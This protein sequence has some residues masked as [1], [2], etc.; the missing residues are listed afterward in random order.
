MPTLRR[1]LRALAA[2]LVAL[3]ALAGGGTPE[4]REVPPERATVELKDKAGKHLELALEE[5]AF[6]RLLL[7]LKQTGKPIE[8]RVEIAGLFA[9]FHEVRAVPDLVA[10]VQAKNEPMALKTAALW[11]LGEIGHPRGMPAFQ[12]VLMQLYDLKDNE[13]KQAKGITVEG[14]G[15]KERTISLREMC[16][17]RLGRLAE[18]VLLK[19]GADEN[20]GLVDIL[21]EPLAKGITPEKPPDE[22]DPANGRRRAALISVAAVG[23]RSPTAIR[24]LTDVLTADDNCYPWDFKLIATEA[25]ST[26][27]IRRTEEFRA[28]GLKARDR[29]SDDIAAALIQAFG[30]TDFPEVREIGG[31]AL[32]RTGWAD[33]A[34]KSLVSVLKALP[35]G[36]DADPKDPTRKVRY[37]I[38]EAL[39]VLKSKE[40]VDH[41][42]FLMFDPDRNI[43]WRAAVALGTCG[44]RRAADFLR[45]LLKD[46]K[47]HFVRVKAVAALGHLQTPAVLPDL[48]VA[49]TDPDFRVRRQAALALGRLGLRQAIPV[50][51][52]T[53]LKDKSPSVRA[54]SIIALGYIT[55]AEGLKA[56]PP[57]LADSDAGVRRVAV[58]VLDK[59]INPGATRALVGALGDADAGVR[60]DAARAVA[61]RLASK[62]AE[63]LGLV[64]DAIEGSRGAARLAAVQCVAADYHKARAAKDAS[65]RRLY[66]RQLDDPKEGLAAGLIAALGDAEPAVRAAAGKLLMDHGVA[67]KSK[68]LLAPVAALTADKDGEV[69]RIGVLARNYLNSI[70]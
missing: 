49:M 67:S 47:D 10:I 42:G 11:A 30:V 34:A 64:A 6:K 25:L 5:K 4:D 1:T 23:D 57:M 65:R 54:V 70:K 33:R 3:P 53:G 31:E 66:E 40:A 37:R 46:D 56:V 44:D 8:L 19:Q 68:E 36:K 62:P 38:I 7:E 13:W 22:N 58:Q 51:V 18:K 55:R 27:L 21:L 61:D 32:Q 9:Y 20:P 26:I 63:A 43:R 52:N 41:L 59:F 12:F 28:S 69:R 24:A 39:A 45:T 14:E 2:L 35:G 16:E 50:L 29:V 17:A 60:E 48:A 15:G